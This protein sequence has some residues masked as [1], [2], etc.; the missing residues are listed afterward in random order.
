MDC[1]YSCF[2]TVTVVTAANE[3]LWEDSQEQQISD[4]SRRDAAEY[5]RG[6]VQPHQNIQSLFTIQTLKILSMVIIS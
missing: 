2:I 3:T 4:A 6:K 5:L 1:V